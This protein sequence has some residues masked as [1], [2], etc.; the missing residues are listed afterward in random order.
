[1]RGAPFTDDER[2]ALIEYCEGDVV[3]LERLLLA[4]LPTID[5]YPAVFRGR[6]MGAVARMVHNGVPIDTT[7]WNPLKDNW[8]V[9]QDDLIREVDRNYGVFVEGGRAPNQKLLERFVAK[10]RLPWPRT[11][12]GRLSTNSD[13]LRSLAKDFPMLNDLKEL[14][15]T[16][17]TFRLG[18]QMR[19]GSDGRNRYD[20]WPFSS[21]TGR[22]QPSPKNAIFG[23]AVWLRGLIR[24]QP[25]MAIAYLD[26]KS[27]EIAIAAALSGD[28]RMMKAY[29]KGD[30]YVNFAI[31]AG[32]LPTNATK[33]SHPEIRDRMKACAR[34]QLRTRADESRRGTGRVRG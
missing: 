22:N 32:I 23:T 19:I 29:S 21:A 18:P 30:F 28:E 24:P 17:S 9:I 15:S 5:L 2:I 26:W 34:C 14:M 10:H 20:L 8:N 1:M 6:Y 3:A 31:L 7:L 27:Q 4:M 12:T 13:T 25:G 11:K 33:D 16:L